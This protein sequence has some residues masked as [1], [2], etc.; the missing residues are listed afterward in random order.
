MLTKGVMR[1][2]GRGRGHPFR[3]VH[4]PHKQPHK[5]KDLLPGFAKQEVVMLD[6]DVSRLCQGVRCRHKKQVICHILWIPQKKRKLCFL[7]ILIRIVWL[8]TL[9]ICPTT[10]LRCYKTMF[11]R[12]TWFLLTTF[13]LKLTSIFFTDY[14]IFCFL[15]EPI[16]T[17]LHWQKQSFC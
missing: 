12:S 16:L 11:C 17:M 10:W 14:K 3:G 4:C 13:S 9:F 15:C 2:W 5:T 6:V 8:T 1:L 7:L